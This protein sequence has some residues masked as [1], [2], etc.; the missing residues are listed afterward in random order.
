[1]NKYELLY[2]LQQPYNK[3]S[4]DAELWRLKQRAYTDEIRVIQL[5]MSQVDM[6]VEEEVMQLFK[7]IQILRTMGRIVRIE[8]VQPAVAK[9][10]HEVDAYFDT[11]ESHSGHT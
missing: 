4:L 8:S 9:I 7:A 1:M 3:T 6:L 10:M 5:S 11:L 2:E